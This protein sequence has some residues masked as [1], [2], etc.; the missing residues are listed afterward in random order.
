MI[1]ET[2][3][4]RL[5]HMV[6]KKKGTRALDELD[7]NCETAVDMSR[8]LL[9]KILQDNKDTEYGRRYG[10]ADITSVEEYRQKVPFSVYDDYAP[11]IERMIKNNET[12]LISVYPA[13]H[14]A[15]S[16][17]SVGVP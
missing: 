17:G 6:L 14:Y 15:L 13:V 11:Y 5:I 7:R 9:M 1:K 12:D 16:S 3:M 10:F 8:D 4:N 2:V